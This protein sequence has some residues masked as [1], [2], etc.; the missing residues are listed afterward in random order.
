MPTLFVAETVG[1]PGI[2]SPFN[3]QT[4]A[5]KR[6]A[7]LL[8]VTDVARSFGTIAIVDR[9]PGKATHGR[10][11][12]S[13]RARAEAQRIE[14]STPEDV[15]LVIVGRKLARAFEVED[16]PYLR[17][18]TRHYDDGRQR[19]VAVIPHPSA[20]TKWWTQPGHAANARRF[21]GK[22]AK[23]EQQP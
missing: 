18:T 5:G 11:L 8:D 7:E 9:W 1:G 13:G 23:E 2:P 19:S 22:I 16:M 3:P 10:E 12:P 6:L 17:W 14:H 21:L 20:G 4:R 15:R